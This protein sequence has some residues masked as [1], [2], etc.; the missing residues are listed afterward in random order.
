MV[1]KLEELE[2]CLQPGFNILNWNSL[3]IPE[4]IQVRF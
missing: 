4:F 2:S 1:K 3:G